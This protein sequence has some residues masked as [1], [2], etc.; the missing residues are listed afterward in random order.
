MKSDHVAVVVVE[1]H[2]PAS[3]HSTWI[4]RAVDTR[5]E[6]HIA[7]QEAVELARF[8][9]ERRAR[10]M[11]EALD[12]LLSSPTAI[13]IDEPDESPTQFLRRAGRDQ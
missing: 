6:L 4:V 12:L 3:Q 2:K 10:L 13:H 9:T 8:G 1:H 7:A 11:A 5:K